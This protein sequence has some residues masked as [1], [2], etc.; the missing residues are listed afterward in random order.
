MAIEKWEVPNTI[1][2]LRAFLGFTNYYSGYISE[3]AK[4]VAGLQDT[5]KVSREN[6]RIENA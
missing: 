5:L 3:Y 6:G 2:H 1:T 4:V